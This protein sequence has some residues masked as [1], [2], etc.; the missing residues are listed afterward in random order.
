MPQRW[1][2]V[3]RS[4]QQ[5]GRPSVGARRVER[6]P[7]GAKAWI[8]LLRRHL[9]QKI[10]AVDS[11]ANYQAARSG[12]FEIRRPK[13]FRPKWLELGLEQPL[14]I[15]GHGPG[16]PVWCWTCFHRHGAVHQRMIDLP[17]PSAVEL[18]FA[19]SATVYRTAFHAPREMC[20]PPPSLPTLLP[21]FIRATKTEV[22]LPRRNRPVGVQAKK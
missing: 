19:K 11:P 18:G 15:G 13:A 10:P 22:P 6:Q 16:E 5:L 21:C 20:P 17:S 7:K 4:D 9:V 3:A 1:M 8:L 12:R 14:D 2:A